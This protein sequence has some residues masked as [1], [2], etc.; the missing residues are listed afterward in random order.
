MVPS[1][2]K[3]VTERDSVPLP[4]VLEQLPQLPDAQE[5]VQPVVL[6]Q[7]IEVAGLVSEHQLSPTYVP[8]LRLHLTVRVRVPLPQSVEQL[9]QLA[10]SHA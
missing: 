3:H 7:L 5:Y 10:V 1:L 4:Q 6:E 2:R 8:S 9:L